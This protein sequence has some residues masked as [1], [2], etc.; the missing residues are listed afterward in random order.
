MGLS[1]L[2]KRNGKGAVFVFEGSGIFTPDIWEGWDFHPRVRLSFWPQEIFG[3]GKVEF[4][5]KFFNG[6]FSKKFLVFLWKF[7]NRMF[8][9]RFLFFHGNFSIECFPKRFLLLCR[10]KCFKGMFSK[11]IFCFEGFDVVLWP[12]QQSLNLNQTDLTI[13]L[14]K[15]QYFQSNYLLFCG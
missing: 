10:W 15:V 1:P 3:P 4:L 14:E 8:S 7:F 12:C 11:K 5:W 2:K 6:I 9:K 13:H